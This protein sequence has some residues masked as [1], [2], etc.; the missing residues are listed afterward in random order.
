MTAGHPSPLSRADVLAADA[1]AV[2]RLGLPTLCLMENAGRGLADV[3]VAELRRYGLG[4]VIVVAARGNNGGD[5]LVAARHLLRLGVP[6]RVLLANPASSFDSRSD[7][8]LHLGV[9][10]TLGIPVAEASDA[11]SLASAAARL[12]PRGLLVDAVLGTGLSGPVR[13]HAAEVLRWMGSSG[14]P[15]V[16]ADLP[17]GLDADT[18][19]LLGPAP[20]CV[21][22]ATFLGLKRGL[23]L[24]HGPS[25]AGRIVVCDIGVPAGA[26]VRGGSPPSSPQ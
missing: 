14:Q 11:S 1:M 24:G 7:A 6:V 8:G 12:E 21:A 18:G 4:N 2:S 20:R 16:A 3:T 17:S 5:G 22:T 10:R 23:V 13:G 26:I 9:V 19:E 25:L 15:V